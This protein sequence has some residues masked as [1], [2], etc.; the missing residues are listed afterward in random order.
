ML[1]ATT[2][3]NT[4]YQGVVGWRGNS[5]S[6]SIEGYFRDS[7]QLKTKIWLS[8]GDGVATGLLL[9][10]IPELDIPRHGMEHETAQLH[11]ER[12][13]AATSRIHLKD[14]RVLDYESILRQLYPQEDIRV[15]PPA[16]MSFSCTCSRK[17]GE[18]AIEILG[19]V[20]A[21]EELKNKQVLVV[22][23]DFCNQQYVFDKVDVAAIFAKNGT[24]PTDTHLH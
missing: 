21:E 20:E 19:Q 24:P 23:C 13:A 3:K 6:E 4:S 2:Q 5:L 11:W 17:R 16:V 22:T 15:F 12:L 9:Q 10:I 1:D 18:D 14:M 8:V 7:E